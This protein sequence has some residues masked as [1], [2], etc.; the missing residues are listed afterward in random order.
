[1]RAGV[2]RGLR[3]VAVEDVDEPEHAPDAVV[4]DVRACGICGSDLH[5]YNGPPGFIA[6]GQVMGHELAGEVSWVGEAV[7]GLTVGDR[8][9][10]MP[11]LSCGEC[12]GCRRGE[13]QL[14]VRAF[15][16][17]LGFGLPGGFAQ[18]LLVPG[19]EVG[20]NVFH[21][22][23]EVSWEGGALAEPL[24]VVVHATRR[25]GV[26]PDDVAVVLGLGPIGQ[27]LA[28]VLVAGGVQRVVGV[29]RSSFRRAWAQERG[30]SAVADVDDLRAALDGARAD[31]VFEC[32]GVP[33]LAQRAARLVRKGG[34]VMVVAAYE[35]PAPIDVSGFV[36]T[37]L[38][39]RGSSAYAIADFAEAVRLLATGAVS[40]ADIVTESA[41]LEALPDALA[42]QLAGHDALKVVVTP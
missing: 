38:T 40:A 20:R 5:L 29:E 22:G 35:E 7:T 16:P 1:M 9:A 31:V 15:A 37:E 18:R 27:L 17:G 11:I 30:L 25:S 10:A 34:T 39:I 4:I 32:T 12:P 2:Y 41:A 36:V 19:A 3:D 8:V 26:G 13:E 14:C 42:R 23:D 21:L 33:A 6:P 28:R 24:A